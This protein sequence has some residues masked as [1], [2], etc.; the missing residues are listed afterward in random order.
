[1]K[2]LY[3]NHHILPRSRWW[4]NLNENIVRLDKRKHIALHMLFDNNTTSEQIKR[5]IDISTTCL[6]EDVKSDIIKI[7]NNTELDYWYKQWIYK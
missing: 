5:I 3:D 7:L 1:M 4:T 6:T 2:K